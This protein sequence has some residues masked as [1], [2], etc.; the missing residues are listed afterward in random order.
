MR[1]LLAVAA[2]AALT[3]LAT[4]PA[5]SAQSAAAQPA[6][7]DAAGYVEQTAISDLFE[8]S[9]AQAALQ[10]ASSDEVRSFARMMIDDHTKVGEQLAEAAKGQNVA[11]S[12][13]T[14][15]D[16]PHDQRLQDLANATEQDFDRLY[17][18][19]QVEAHTAALKL[20]QDYSSF[21]ANPALKAIATQLVPI[22]KRHL[23][24]AQTILDRLNK[25]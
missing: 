25:A 3:S 23:D 8:I 14:S 17:M 21:G 24:Q 18:R 4:V 10:K 5:A 6:Q 22:V 9:A 19:T 2:F 13:P 16:A 7:T 12:L 20:Q 11:T 15:V 1:R